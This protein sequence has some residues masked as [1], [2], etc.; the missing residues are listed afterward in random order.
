MY[1][2]RSKL[3]LLNLPKVEYEIVES[4]SGD[5]TYYHPRKHTYLPVDVIAADPQLFV[6]EAYA[7]SLFDVEFKINNHQEYVA[8]Y[9]EGAYLQEATDAP[10]YD[11]FT[12]GY[13]QARLISREVELP[14]L[15][16]MIDVR[17]PEPMPV[18]AV[19]FITE[20]IRIV[21][22][23]YEAALRAL[24]LANKLPDEAERQKY[25]ARS[26]GHINRLRAQKHRL[27]KRL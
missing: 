9:I 25:R 7:H 6:R 24:G 13:Q 8:I 2:L 10:L 18:T 22:Q 12:L 19:T 4:R 11:R 26:F 27:E 23:R 14:C 15:T 16:D 5:G 1:K 17:S 21:Q 20:S 3:V